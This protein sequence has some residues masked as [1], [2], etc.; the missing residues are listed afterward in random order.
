MIIRAATRAD[1]PALVAMAGEFLAATRYGTL[2][3]ADAASVGHA[4]A[5]IEALGGLALVAEDAGALV[6]MLALVVGPHPL[7]GEPT[8]EELVWWAA[9][10]ARYAQVGLRLLKAAEAWA[11]AQGIVWL[12]LVEPL[13][14]ETVSRYGRL[15]YTAI[16]T[17]SVKRLPPGGA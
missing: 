1:Q 6:G 17:R 15:G 14:R 8:A 16:E 5:L 10:T 13:P 11:V 3:T 4:L 12:V 2:L 9:P 7:T